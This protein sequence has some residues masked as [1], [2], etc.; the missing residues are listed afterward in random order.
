MYCLLSIS[1]GAFAILGDTAYNIFRHSQYIH[2]DFLVPESTE[3]SR[4]AWTLEAGVVT[5]CEVHEH[6]SF[7]PFGIGGTKGTGPQR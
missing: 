3:F 5:S 4:N 1:L 2:M 7:R 6:P